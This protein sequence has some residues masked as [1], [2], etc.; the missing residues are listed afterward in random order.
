MRENE[1]NALFIILKIVKLQCY[2][3]ITT[4]SF[5]QLNFYIPKQQCYNNNVL[6]I[7]FFVPTKC[8]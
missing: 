5:L 6:K 7:Y 4:I 3:Y 2:Y 1:P 8:Y